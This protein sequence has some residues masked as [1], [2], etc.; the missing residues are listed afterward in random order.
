MIINRKIF[1]INMVRLIFKFFKKTIYH[2]ARQHNIKFED[3]SNYSNI[4]IR[5]KVRMF[6]SKNEDIKS[7]LVKSV[8]LFCALRLYFGQTH[9]KVFLDNVVLKDEGYNNK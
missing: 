3:P 9:I 6:L 4:Y 5:T 8:K 2:Y 1:G 7:N